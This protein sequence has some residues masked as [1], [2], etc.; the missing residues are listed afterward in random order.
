MTCW[1]N[2]LMTSKRLSGLYVRCPLYACWQHIRQSTFIVFIVFQCMLSVS[3]VIRVFTL[4]MQREESHRKQKVGERPQD[5]SLWGGGNF[6]FTYLSE[7]CSCRAFILSGKWQTMYAYARLS[8]VLLLWCLVWRSGNSI[9][10]ICKATLSSVS[11]A[12]GDLW[13]VY[14][15]IIFQ[16][17]HPGHPFLGLCNECWRWF[18]PPMVKKWQVLRSGVWCALP[19]GLLAYWLKTVKDTSCYFELGIRPTSVLC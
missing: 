1:Q 5:L 16:A 15:P 18:R 3:K 9:G 10:H 6:Y 4:H 12:V 11:T 8:M 17:T 14:H 19:P 7:K 13:R 2:R